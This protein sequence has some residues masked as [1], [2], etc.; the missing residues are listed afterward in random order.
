M[1]RMGLLLLL[2]I[3]IA[4]PAI[5]DEQF[6]WTMEDAPL[7]VDIPV[8]L[9]A[10]LSDVWKVRISIEG[11]GGLQYATCPDGGDY[12]ELE[13][14]YGLDVDLDGWGWEMPE[15]PAVPF[16]DAWMRAFEDFS[17][18]EDGQAT[19]RLNLLVPDLDSNSGCYYSGSDPL[20]VSSVTVIVDCLAALPSDPLDWSA[21]K[22]WYR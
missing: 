2:L 8:H 20:T 9:N 22:A 4:T 17:S 13:L 18:F 19:L 6:I 3:L 1:Y 15:L 10:E 5:A 11:R 7:S 12:Y 21:I 16:S 14:P